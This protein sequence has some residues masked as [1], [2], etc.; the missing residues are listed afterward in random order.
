M[1]SSA[2]TEASASVFEVSGDGFSVQL[3]I[4]A[5]VA[6]LYPGLRFDHAVSGSSIASSTGSV[7]PMIRLRASGIWCEAL[8]TMCIR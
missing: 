7:P 8:S 3:M 1:R 2:T 4:V 6:A 5:F